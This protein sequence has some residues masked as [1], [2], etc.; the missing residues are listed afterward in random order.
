VVGIRDLIDHGETGILAG[1]A[2]FKGLAN[3]VISLLENPSLLTKLSDNAK[4][5]TNV[6]FNFNEGIKD[7]QEFYDSLTYQY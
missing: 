5:I 7:Y 3:A 2:D 4:T 6:N 1:E